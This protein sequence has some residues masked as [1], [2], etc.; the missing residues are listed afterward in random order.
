MFPAIVRISGSL[1]VFLLIGVIL[2]FMAIEQLSIALSIL[3]A[4]LFPV[5]WFSKKTL[6]IDNESKTIAT[7]FHVLSRNFPRTCYNFKSIEKIII[8]K[9]HNNYSLL[10]VLDG[11]KLVVLAKNRSKESAMKEVHQ[12]KKKLALSAPIL[13]NN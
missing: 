12:L 6:T 8:E 2:S 4:M 9:K 5:L 13:I 10:L 3:I 7:S 11:S 1:L